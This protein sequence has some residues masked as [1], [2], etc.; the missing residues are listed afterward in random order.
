[1]AALWG[2]YQL[3]LKTFPLATMSGTTCIIMS[4]GDCVSQLAI[5]RKT[6]RQY[7]FVRTGRFAVA[8]LFVFGPVMRGWY[9]TLDK[10]YN[11]TRLA[12]IKMMA[13]DQ[14]IMA[15]TFVGLFISLMAVMRQESL[16]SIKGKLKRDYSVVLLNNYK[17]W[18]MAQL[19]NFYFLP[20][21]HRVLFVNFI[22][23]GWNTYL[24]WA[25]EK[26]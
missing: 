21:Q 23:L 13:T 6:R 24:A 14:L 22:A 7:D 5:E 4:A 9:L 15:P 18:P 16:D 11:G 17:I 20:L 25:T 26:N 12:A 3:L 19:I 8:G 10:L 1:M 2:R